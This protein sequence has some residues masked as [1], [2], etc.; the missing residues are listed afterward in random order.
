M[1]NEKW[2]R[3]EYGKYNKR[4]PFFNNDPKKYYWNGF[5]SNGKERWY[6]E[7]ENGTLITNNN[8]EF[9]YWLRRFLKRY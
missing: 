6:L 4:L 7:F 1:D 5:N 9:D 3:V 8:L 2:K